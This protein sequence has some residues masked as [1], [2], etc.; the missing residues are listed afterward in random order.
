MNEN[1]I[2][3][4]RKI[5]DLMRDGMY[6][7]SINDLLMRIKARLPQLKALLAQIEDHSGEEDRV[8]R[9]T[10]TRSKSFTC[11]S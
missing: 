4:L 8:Y 3:Y 9:F 6:E 11:R 2:R 10:T 1:E 7:A 5:R